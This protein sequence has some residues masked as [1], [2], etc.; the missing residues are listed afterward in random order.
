MAF[1]IFDTPIL[2]AVLHLAA[3]ILLRIRGWALEGRL[4]DL[5][6][7]VVIAAPHTSNWDLPV[8]LAIAFAFRARVFW[9]GKEAIFRRPF[10]GF[11]RWL[12]GIPIDRS[13]SN[14]AVAQSIELFRRNPKL[15]LVVPPEGTR[16]K[17]RSWKTGF[18]YIASG[19]GVPIALGFIDYRRKA[20]GFGPLL[21]P[22]GDIVADMRQ[23]RAF[24]STVS[25]K[26]PERSGEASL[27]PADGPAPPG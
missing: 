26:Y 23:I 4:P 6:Q 27:A 8:M 7:Y 24:Y 5:P 25:G 2:N 14:D 18:Y 21:V 20:G 1:T 22:T 17:V 19:A 3:R 15:V 16:R 12:G 10:G 9:M 13:R 11:F